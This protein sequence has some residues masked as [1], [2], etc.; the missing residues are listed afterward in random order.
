MVRIRAANCMKLQP[1]CFW[2]RKLLQS[3]PSSKM[4]LRWRAGCDTAEDSPTAL[5]RH[6]QEHGHRVETAR[7]VLAG[8]SK[9]LQAW[10]FPATHAA[11][12]RHGNTQGNVEKP[13]L[14]ADAQ[15]ATPG[16]GDGQTAQDADCWLE[17]IHQTESNMNRYSVFA[18]AI[19]AFLGFFAGAAFAVDGVKLIDQN[20]ALV[21]NTRGGVGGAPGFPVTIDQPGSYRLSGNLTVPPDINGIEIASDDVTL[22]LNGFRIAGSGVAKGISEEGGAAYA[23]VKIHNGT[24]IGFSQSIFLINSTQVTVQDVR[25]TNQGGA[26]VVVGKFALLQRNNVQGLIQA[27]CPSV[28]TENITE[29]FLTVFVAANETCVRWN[30]RSLSFDTPV[31]Q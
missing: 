21:G 26:S 31:T 1:P 27:V 20:T 25:A 24:L 10:C 14:N 23:R 29:G 8:F 15:L 13:N 12:F 28:I 11:L 30:N 4:A 3:K 19:C 2:A 7:Q 9:T 5:G 16:A 22:D 18:V 6:Q 17:T